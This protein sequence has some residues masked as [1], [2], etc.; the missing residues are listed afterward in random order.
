MPNT[1]TTSNDP[2]MQYEES[3]SQGFPFSAFFQPSSSVS[4][5]LSIHRPTPGPIPAGGLGN[6]NASTDVLRSSLSSAAFDSTSSLSSFIGFSWGPPLDAIP[7]AVPTGSS[8]DPEHGIE[9]RNTRPTLI[10][11]PIHGITALGAHDSL[12]VPTFGPS[13]GSILS[14]PRPLANN[15]PYN[16]STPRR[17]YALSPFHTLQRTS[18]I[19]RSN[20]PRRSVS[21][22][23]AMKQLVDCVGMSARKKVL[24]SGRKPRVIGLWSLG[25]K[26]GGV[27]SEGTGR[28]AAYKK[29]LR[30]DPL[31]TPI[32]RPDYRALDPNSETGH[33]NSSSYGHIS[34]NNNDDKQR[35]IQPQVYTYNYPSSEGTN[36]DSEDGV[37]DPPSPSPSPR[38]G[39]A[40]SMISMSRR[41]GTPTTSTMLMTS[42]SA[43]NL[44]ATGTLSSHRG[45]NSVYLNIPSAPS[46]G[47]LNSNF[48]LG[49]PPG[50]AAAA[51]DLTTIIPPR[52]RNLEECQKRSESDPHHNHILHNGSK[53]N[54]IQDRYD[55]D[56]AT[57]PNVSSLTQSDQKPQWEALERRHAV[58]M[59]DIEDLEERIKGLNSTL[60]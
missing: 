18:T 44:T 9:D 32:P 46:A 11:V 4:S 28:G 42:G 8:A 38:P 12:L 21:D 5:G 19:R 15:V 30:F 14:T 43:H 53:R 13:G 24:E 58:M 27:K 47:P 56:E 39:S 35:N 40:M 45:N 2:P 48:K 20:A 3:L 16:Y 23:E 34:N 26:S 6:G 17:P 29:E 22:R 52:S 60:F 31:A 33:R 7:L 49:C 55:D 57:V 54:R 36:T 59:G 1:G 51:A 50:I 25:G 10:P 37:G 41:S